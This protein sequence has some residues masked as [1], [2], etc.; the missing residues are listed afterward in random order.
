MSSS[1]ET[2]ELSPWKLPRKKESSDKSATEK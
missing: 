1:S 2:D